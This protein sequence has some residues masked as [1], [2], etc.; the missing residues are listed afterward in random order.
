[1][2]SF[3]RETGSTETTRDRPSSSGQHLSE[4]PSILV[5]DVLVSV[6]L[7]NGRRLT[8][9]PSG[10]LIAPFTRRLL[11]RRNLVQS[12]ALRFHPHVGVSREHGAGDVAGD[13]HDHMV[14]R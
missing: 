5:S 4:G 6:C 10:V 1:V 9:T 11:P 3:I 14:A 7:L 13:A 8:D 2:N 12:P